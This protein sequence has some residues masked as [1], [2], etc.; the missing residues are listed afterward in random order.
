MMV[1]RPTTRPAPMNDDLTLLGN[2]YLRIWFASRYGV[3]AEIA[4]ES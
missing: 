2:N 4:I 3:L 1:C